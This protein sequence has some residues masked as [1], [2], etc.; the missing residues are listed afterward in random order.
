[1]ALHSDVVFG[2]SCTR[3][4]RLAALM[5]LRIEKKNTSMHHTPWSTKHLYNT[6]DPVTWR[7]RTFQGKEEESTSHYFQL[8]KLIICAKTNYDHYDYDHFLSFSFPLFFKMIE[9]RTGNVNTM[10]QINEWYRI[11][12]TTKRNLTNITLNVTVYFCWLDHETWQNKRNL[13]AGRFNIRVQVNLGQINSTLLRQSWSSHLLLSPPHE[14]DSK[15]AKKKKKEKKSEIREL[16][17]QRQ[18]ETGQLYCWIWGW[19]V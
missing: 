9:M 4:W 14:C 3:P 16:W 6:H 1:M 2:S 10:M 17:S 12:S 13:N 8:E 7:Y 11:T 19:S 15:P 5:N 18:E